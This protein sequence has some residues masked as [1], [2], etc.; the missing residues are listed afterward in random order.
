MKLVIA[1]LCVLLYGDKLA[2]QQQSVHTRYEAKLEALAPSNP[3]GYFLLAEEVADVANKN[4][5]IELARRLYVLAIVLSENKPQV[6]K[7]AGFPVTASASVGLASLEKIE[8]KKQWLFALAGRIDERYAARR[9][10]VTGSDLVADEASLLL[11]EAIG[12]T[13][14]GDGSLART[15]FDDPRVSSLLEETSDGVN[16]P[17][18]RASATQILREADIW[19][20]PECS[21]AR[22]VA[23][24][25]K[26]G[27][28]RRL[29][30]TCRGNPGPVL[31]KQTF[32]DYLA[33]QSALLEG[34]QKSWSSELAVEGAAPLRDPDVSEIAPTMGV[35]PELVYFRSGEW[36]SREAVLEN[37]DG[38]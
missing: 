8:S 5:D 21:N 7:S 17:T 34:N 12:L 27:S 35:D 22:I 3:L 38:G 26:G 20:C 13:L 30:S 16:G 37:V 24:R 4:D 19:P 2:A 10:D 11:S 31:D 36:V 33:F 6:D 1:I 15:R 29:C 9:W 14:S 23:D 28:A 25:S 18:S 32:I